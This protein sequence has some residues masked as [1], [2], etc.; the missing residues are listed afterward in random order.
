MSD[1]PAVSIADEICAQIDSWEDGWQS[2]VAAER[3]RCARIAADHECDGYDCL[4][5]H[6]IAYRIRSGE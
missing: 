5:Y 4:C 1:Q 2:G 6:V 3:E